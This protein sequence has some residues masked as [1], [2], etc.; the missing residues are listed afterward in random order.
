MR[1]VVCSNV[2]PPHFIGGAELIA[3]Q[4]AK[5]LAALGHEV[6]VY[7]GDHMLHAPRHVAR[8]DS[9]DG[10]SVR[11][12][13]LTG[14]DFNPAYVSFFHPAIERDFA[15]FVARVKPD[16]VHFHN[17]VGLSLKLISIAK[18]AGARTVL[19]LHDYWGFCF[20]NTAMKT[21]TEPCRDVTRC[22]ECLSHVDDGAD[23]R[24]PIRLRQD[25]FREFLLADV[26]LFVSPSAY[27]ADQYVAAGFD[28]RRMRV[29]WNG[30]DTARFGR[31]ALDPIPEAVRFSFFGYLGW[32]KGIHL[33]IDALAQLPDP[34]RAR[35]NI[36]GDG[37]LKRFYMDAVQ[38]V[39]CRH[40]VRFWGKIDNQAVEHAYAETDVL[41]LPS[42]WPENQPV[43][44]TEAMAS[45]R[46]VIAS[47]MGGSRELVVHGVTGFLFEPEDVHGLAAAMQKFVSEPRLVE[48]MG[49]KGR[50]RIAQ[51]TFASQAAKLLALYRSSVPGDPEDESPPIVACLGD[52][53]PEGSDAVA[54]TA[55]ARVGSPIRFL[56][57]DWVPQ[58]SA[59]RVAAHWRV[60]GD[61]PPEARVDHDLQSAEVSTSD[62]D[63]A[64]ER[65]VALLGR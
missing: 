57:A 61:P 39:G 29:V 47:G 62:P 8:D 2:Y 38:A 4:Q 28:R 1:I 37:E 51:A 64:V 32:H 36:V 31:I 26:D 48:A 23:R 46:P 15:D 33:L 13:R 34:T 11:R 5:A 16:V 53:F 21:P 50:A 3:H 35:L 55:E 18:E 41:V 52:R 40:L 63:R 45:G 65:I 19:T 60:D 22:H 56:H 9:Y 59:A 49:E 20:K 7:A 30:I 43:S 6:S 25:A 42:L 54:P 12:I 58:R 44:I 14:D 27:L 24:I 10:L 17:I